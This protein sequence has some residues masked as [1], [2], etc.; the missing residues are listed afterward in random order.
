MCINKVYQIKFKKMILEINFFHSGNSDKNLFKRFSN[1]VIMPER[2]FK[3]IYR[4][5]LV[6]KNNMIELPSGIVNTLEYN[7]HLW[8]AHHPLEKRE[9]DYGKNLEDSIMMYI[10]NV[11]PGNHIKAFHPAHLDDKARNTFK[12]IY[13]TSVD[14]YHRLLLTGDADWHNK[15]VDIKGED[16]QFSIRIKNS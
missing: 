1:P 13:W 6:D 14:E 3:G 10:T 4:N 12:R 2:S 7:D 11:M 5:L 9:R 16:Y 8:R 15:I